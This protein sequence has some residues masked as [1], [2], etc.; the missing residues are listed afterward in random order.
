VRTALSFLIL[1]LASLSGAFDRPGDEFI[2]QIEALQA[3]KWEEAKHQDKVYVAEYMKQI[4]AHIRTRN[5][6][7]LR[8]FQEDADHPRT[9]ELM[10]KRWLEFEGGRVG[11]G[12]AYQQRVVADIEQILATNPKPVIVEVAEYA[13]ARVLM[14]RMEAFQ[15]DPTEVA[16]RFSARF[17]ASKYGEELLMVAANQAPSS[18]GK[19]RLLTR[20][21]NLYPTGK[22]SVTAKGKLRRLDN[23]G[24]PF[25]LKFKDV[26]SGREINTTQMQ[27]KVIVVDFWATWCGPCIEKMPELRAL[28]QEL[29][30]EGLEVVGV[31]LDL[32]ERE[33]GK[34]DLLKFIREQK[35]PW[36]NYYLGNGW[37]SDYAVSWGITSIPTV[38]IIDR[39]GNLHSLG[40][41]EIGQQLRRLLKA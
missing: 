30:S 25:A 40:N 4:A 33:G 5:E 32:P 15:E 9:A 11:S 35:V 6:L 2:R 7:I 29:K 22:W 34:T 17:P 19:R 27:G 18:E 14:E 37:D 38:F 28:Y 23:M 41:R 31:S 39:K 16:M 21:L 3:P 26:L 12:E 36:P 10:L 8:L 24:K 1:V 20:L 13:R